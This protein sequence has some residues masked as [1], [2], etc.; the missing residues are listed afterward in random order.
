MIEL[1]LKAH[2]GSFQLEVKCELAKHWTVIFG[3]SGAGKSTLLRLIA[4]LERVNSGRIL[5][6]G[7]AVTDAG[8]GFHS[9][10][11]NRR[12]GLVAQQPALFPHLSV[13]QNVAYGL[14]KRSAREQEDQ[15]LEMLKLTG[16]EHLLNRAVRSLSGGEAQRVS[17]ART[18]APMPRVLL[19]DEPLSALGAD[20]RDLVLSKLQTW[21]AE[22]RI[23]TVLVTHDAADA[24]ATSAEVVLINEGRLISQGPAGE[25]LATERDRILARLRSSPEI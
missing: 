22:K 16:A 23:Q 2:R 25:V 11:G 19:L 9:P 5:I 24:L 8:S 17:L 15:V 10:A 18:L 14:N 3:P 12:T 6:A 20:A 7:E 13:R 1:D 21:L 4:G